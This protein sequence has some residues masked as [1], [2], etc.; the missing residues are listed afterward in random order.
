MNTVRDK[1]LS[2]CLLLLLSGLCY[3]DTIVYKGPD[4]N[5]KQI[6]GQIT[7]ETSDSYFILV[8]GLNVPVPK[9]QVIEVIRTSKPA[10]PTPTPEPVVPVPT[11]TPETPAPVEPLAP[12]PTPTR[13]QTETPLGELGGEVPSAPSPITPTPPPVELVT[14]ENAPLLPVV[15]AQGKPYRVQGSVRLR[16]G[17][18]VA[19][20]EVETLPSLAILIGFEEMDNWI[21]ARTVNGTEGWVHSNFVMPLEAIP[22]IVSSNTNIRQYA[23]EVYNIIAPLRKGD[24]VLKLDENKEWWY[25]LYNNTIAGWCNSQNLRLLDNPALYKPVM[26]LVRNSDIPQPPVL[27]QKIP[28]DSAQMYLTFT[29]RDDR[30]TLGGMTKLIVFFRDQELFKR[31]NLNYVSEN[32]VQKQRLNSSMEIL[33][34]GFPEELSINFIG[35]DILTMM[36]E[37]VDT[38]WQYTLT[39]PESPMIEFAF[40]VQETEMRGNVI[41]VQQP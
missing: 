41:L 32:I 39:M 15:I 23:G 33:Q 24:V 14:A 1:F 40:I 8:D 11:P 17:P 9:T 31:P 29:L 21:H 18:D 12:T 37:R 6:I 38:G 28:A 13:F 19:A 36:G 10:E 20:P 27:V 22:C 2:L 3:A 4:G 35:A 16:Q 25:I 7:Q 5:P 26:S 30:L 34:T